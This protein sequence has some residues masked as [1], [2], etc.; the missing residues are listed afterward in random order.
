MLK[1]IYPYSNG[2]DARYY[3]CSDLKE[4]V[5]DFLSLYKQQ[6]EIGGIGRPSDKISGFNRIFSKVRTCPVYRFGSSKQ[7]FSER[8]L[9]LVICDLL[10]TWNVFLV[11]S[12][13]SVNSIPGDERFRSMHKRMEVILEYIKYDFE[14]LLSRLSLSPSIDASN[15]YKKVVIECRRR[16][17]DKNDAITIRL[18]KSLKSPSDYTPP[19]VTPMTD[20]INR[21]S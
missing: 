2:S 10:E 20:E 16:S 21:I 11:R 3:K 17:G 4:L 1:Q 18:I 9:T 7:Y 12:N 13:P 5:F 19:M 6:W 14:Y 8:D 15:L